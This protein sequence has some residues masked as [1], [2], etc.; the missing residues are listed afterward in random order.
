MRLRSGNTYEMHPRLRRIIADDITPPNSP[1]VSPN[2]GVSLG[3]GTLSLMLRYRQRA[4]AD[5]CSN[6]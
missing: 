1:D 4:S 5:I 3:N 6:I 2:A